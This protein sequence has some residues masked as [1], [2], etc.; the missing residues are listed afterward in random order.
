MEQWLILTN[1]VN[2][3]QYNRNPTDFYDLD[4]KAIDQKSHRKIYDRLKE[5]DRQVLELDFGDSPDKLKGEYIDMSEGVKSEV[6]STTK[7]DENSDLCM[8]Y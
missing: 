1:V 8:T 7:F 6:F 5:E 4:I 2:Y 3:V